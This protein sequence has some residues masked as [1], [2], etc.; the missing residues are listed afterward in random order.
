MDQADGTDRGINLGWY[1][2]AW[3]TV[4]HGSERDFW[5]TMTPRR[6]GILLREYYGPRQETQQRSLSD[7]LAGGG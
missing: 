3:L 1:L 4:F 6:L 2:M 7:Y 5:K